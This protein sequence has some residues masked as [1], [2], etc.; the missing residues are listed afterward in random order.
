MY[1]PHTLTIEPTSLANTHVSD[2]SKFFEAE[3]RLISKYGERESH[4]D[5]YFELATF[6]PLTG[7]DVDYFKSS[8]S[9]RMLNFIVTIETWLFNS[10][11]GHQRAVFE[12]AKTE[13][14]IAWGLSGLSQSR[15][16]DR[17]CAFLQMALLFQK[18]TDDRK[19][20]A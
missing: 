19:D 3:E 6:Y 15:R 12:L 11:N 14:S 17:Q 18:S 16:A 1:I 20:S 8:I 13:D 7:V 5:R 4:P 2:T 10:A 9:I